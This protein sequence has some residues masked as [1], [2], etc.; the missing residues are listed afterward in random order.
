MADITNYAQRAVALLAGQFQDN[1][2]VD[3]TTNLQKLIYA[4]STAS[5][6]I[7][8][9]LN[10]L[11]SDRWIPTGQGMQLDNMGEILGLQRIPGQPDDSATINGVY[12]QGYREALQFQIFINISS[13]TPEQVIAA[14]KYFTN[15]DKIW[16]IE[17]LPAA[18][19]L[20]T[21]GLTFPANPSD[22]VTAIRN[23]SPAGVGFNAV[24]ATYNQIPFVFTSDVALDPLYVVSDPTNL[25]ASAQLELNSSYFLYVNAGSLIDPTFGG[26][27]A[28]FGYPIDK[29]GAGALTE[30]IMING[31]LPP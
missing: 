31:N 14:L 27:F 6:N 29:T 21:D 7:Q 24:I 4:I 18:Y 13:G 1:S 30:A 25:G 19:T 12:V 15:A 10:N 3:A 2:N 20:A 22:L 8:T 28:E 17:T 23:I 5:Q 26:G 9:Q 16:Y 11:L